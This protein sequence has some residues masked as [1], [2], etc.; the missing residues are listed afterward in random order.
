MTTF[1]QRGPASHG[2]LRRAAQF[3]LTLLLSI[4]PAFAAD[5]TPSAPAPAQASAQRDSRPPQTEAELRAALKDARFVYVSYRAIRNNAE[6]DFDRTKDR[7]GRVYAEDIY[8]NL[9]TLEAK[10]RIDALLENASNALRAHDLTSARTALEELEAKLKAQASLYA[11]IQLYWVKLGDHWPD[12]GPYLESLRKSGI[13]PHLQTE[14]ESTEGEL[15]NQLEA[16][17]FSDAMSR[18]YPALQALYRRAGAEDAAEIEAALARGQPY[19]PLLHA[20]G[21]GNC[22][23]PGPAVSGSRPVSIAAPAPADADTYPSKSKRAEAEG[24]SRIY[25]RVS[26]EGCLIRAMITVTS[27]WAD[28]DASALRWAL[29]TKWAA[30]VSDSQAVTQ[31][32]G[33][34]MDFKLKD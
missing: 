32:A 3:A 30:A 22:S 11:G 19:E 1:A 2:M 26:A 4:S 14:I 17:Q 8:R 12:R 28:L 9:L 16:N 21:K 23:K 10:R 31:G 15:R 33:F 13:T 27:G 6:V 25:V 7:L 20:E 29:K 24:R 34:W 18:L 5:T